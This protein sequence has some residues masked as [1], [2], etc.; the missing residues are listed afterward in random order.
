[1]AQLKAV[2]GESTWFMPQAV[3]EVAWSF[4]LGTATGNASTTITPMT[5]ANTATSLR[6]VLR[7]DAAEEYLVIHNIGGEAEEKIGSRYRS[8]RTKAYANLPSQASLDKTASSTSSHTGAHEALEAI[9]PRVTANA[10]TISQCHKYQR[11]SPSRALLGGD[12]ALQPAGVPKGTTTFLTSSAESMQA[13]SALAVE[14]DEGKCVPA[15]ISRNGCMLPANSQDAREECSYIS[16]T[17]LALEL[18]DKAGFPDVSIPSD[19]D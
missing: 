8:Y 1:V 14:A 4:P 19:C 7:G 13:V 11:R 2:V 12:L 5:S 10:S 6:W 9:R 3:V 17:L 18:G 15:G 16:A